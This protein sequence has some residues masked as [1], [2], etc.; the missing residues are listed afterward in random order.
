MSHHMHHCSSFDFRDTKV[1][2]QSFS[3]WCT[4]SKSILA[5][6]EHFSQFRDPCKNCLSE[7]FLAVWKVNFDFFCHFLVLYDDKVQL[8]T[9]KKAKKKFRWAIFAG[10][11]K[12]GKVFSFICI[13]ESKTLLCFFSFELKLIHSWD[14][15]KLVD[16]VENIVNKLLKLAKQV[17]YYRLQIETGWV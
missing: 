16:T 1:D 6:A 9:P 12:L 5:K 15:L 10:V 11:S 17:W 8:T 2:V 3:E 4:W 13:I 7:L 14:W